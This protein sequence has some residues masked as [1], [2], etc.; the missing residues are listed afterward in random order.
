MD[1]LTALNDK[2]ASAAEAWLTDPTDVRAYGRLVNAVRERRAHLTPTLDV[3]PDDPGPL[4]RPEQPTT[5]PNTPGE[6]TTAGPSPSDPEQPDE[7]L[8][9]LAD[10]HPVQP[11]SAALAGRD[12]REILARLRGAPTSGSR[13][14]D[15]QT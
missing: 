12:P 1:E 10:Q 13:P 7:L 8:D 2:V 3:L 6:T 14:D 5:G 9:G 15:E 4:R 11:L